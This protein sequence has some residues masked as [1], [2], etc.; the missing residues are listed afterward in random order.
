MFDLFRS[1]EK[2]VRIMLSGL[3]LV[4][5]ASML[6]YLVPNYNTDGGANDVIVAEVG[7]EAITLPEVQN[8]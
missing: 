1:R 2:T 8:I 5:A 4:V 7:K 3:L 6:V